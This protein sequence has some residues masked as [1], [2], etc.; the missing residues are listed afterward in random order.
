MQELDNF[1]RYK[2]AALLAEFRFVGEILSPAAA[3]EGAQ[4]ENLGIIWSALA[5]DLR[6]WPTVNHPK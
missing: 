1:G 3:G 4:A 2:E 5:D 6:T